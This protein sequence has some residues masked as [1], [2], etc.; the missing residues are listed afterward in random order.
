MVSR[1]NFTRLLVLLLLNGVELNLGNYKTGKE[2]VEVACAGRAVADELTG[3][4]R[5]SHLTSV[6]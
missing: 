2:G 1:L 4:Y 6:P 3:K 5:L